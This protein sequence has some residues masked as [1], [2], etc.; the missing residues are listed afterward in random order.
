M[1]PRRHQLWHT[2][3]PLKSAKIA[4][5]VKPEEPAIVAKK[6]LTPMKA[7]K[8]IKKWAATKRP[9]DG[10]LPARK[11]SKVEAAPE[12]DMDKTWQRLQ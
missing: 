6:A 1:P 7:A 11:K 3:L 9:S 10:S 4:S 5:I 8:E 12:V 2:S